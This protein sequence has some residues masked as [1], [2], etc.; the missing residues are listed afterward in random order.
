VRRSE[1]I[2]LF[3]SAATIDL[4]AQKKRINPVPIA[5]RVWKAPAEQRRYQIRHIVLAYFS[6]P[7]V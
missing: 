6:L 1:F 7:P 3:G 2:A 4:S 5:V